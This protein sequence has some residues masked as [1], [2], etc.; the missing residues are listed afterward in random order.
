MENRD[1]ADL[2][3][4]DIATY[5]FR[6]WTVIRFWKQDSYDGMKFAMQF[7]KQDNC[8]FCPDDYKLMSEFMHQCY[9]YTQN[10]VDD[11]KHVRVS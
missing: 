11:V 7:Q 4:T 6:G 2:E 8:I 9:L 10:Q 5:N 3:R 1:Y